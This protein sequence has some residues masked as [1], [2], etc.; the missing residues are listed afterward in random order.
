[1]SQERLAPRTMEKI[2][3]TRIISFRFNDRVIKA[4]PGD[5]VA[6][7]L[8]ASGQRI[9]VRSFKYHR[10]R[11]LLC[12][13]G[14]CPNCMMNV[15]GNPNTRTCKMQVREGIIVR[16]QNAWPSLNHD[17]ASI[18]DKFDFLTPV[19]FYY[20]SFIHPKWMWSAARRIVKR[21]TGIGVIN[22][23]VKGSDGY[24]HANK[25]VDIAI[26]GGGPAGL[27]AAIEASRYGI[28]VLLV[29]EQFDLGGHLKF[30]QTICQNCG[31]FSGLKGFE[32]AQRLSSKV[33]ASPNIEVLT[34]ATCIAIYEG[35]LLTIAQ[36][37]KLLN[38]RASK[39]IICTGCHEH[40]LIFANNDLP[41]IF[42]GSALQRLVN[43]YAL[44]PDGQV[45][46]VT[47]N[48]YGYEVAADLLKAGI[49]VVALSD[50]RAT[51]EQ[52]SV[53][54]R[55]LQ[56]KGVEILP[57]HTIIRA[58]GRKAVDHAIVAKTDRQGNI[59]PQTNRRISCAAI[60]LSVGF[61]AENA[62]LYQAGC[63]F[64]FDEK[65]GE[66]EPREMDTG[67]YAAGEVT[68]LHSL[69]ISIPQGTMNGA[70]AALD[71]FKTDEIVGDL[72]HVQHSEEINRLDQKVARYSGDLDGLIS[73]YKARTETSLLIAIPDS[74]GKKLACVCE[75]V[76]EKDL[77]DAIEEGFDE[78][79][80]LKR[81]STFSMG[82]CQGK[83]CNLSCTAVYAKA[84][85][86][87]L[88]KIA[89]TTSR[90][91]Y[92]PVPLGM[93]AGQPKIVY[94]ITPMHH[95]H[96]ALKARSMDHGDW[97]RPYDYGS[98]ELE[99]KA[100]REGVGLIDVSTL[101]RFE[102]RGR[103]AAKFLDLTFGNIYS[104][105]KLGK[106]R[107]APIFTET[108]IV[109]DD[110]IIARLGNEEFLV[111]CGTGGTE[112]FEEYVKYWAE[113]YENAFRE[114]KGCLHITNLTAG[115][116]AVNIAGPKAREVLSRLTDMDLSAENLPYMSCNRATVAGVQSILLR[117][118]FVG[119]AG[120]EVHFP[121]EYGEYLWDTIMKAGE[122]FG[123]R[124]VGVE[125]MKILRL[126]KKILWPDIDTDR[127]SDGLETGLG[128]SIKFEKEDFVGKH[129]LEKTQQRGFKQ[130]LVGF[131]VDGDS[132]VSEG[133]LIMDR[134]NIVGR[135]TSCRYSIV[136]KKRVG[137][138]WVP[139][140]LA[141]DGGSIEV[142]HR[143]KTSEGKIVQRAFY[144]PEGKRVKE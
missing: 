20:K 84:T 121:A 40:P 12:L 90:P 119:E 27:S 75:D 67:V 124:P 64:D 96:Q 42:L 107:Y 92:E 18:I 30:S 11:G 16:H 125:A 58:G 14:K 56:E 78:I 115:L 108:G 117:I 120:W 83:M 86:Q 54:V 103:D 104:N 38:V 76:T 59:I 143:G 89:R 144:D 25:H 24:D 45:V 37:K 1:M 17:F 46:V 95:K 33:H 9:F 62:L 137:L 97:K 49:A 26:I 8:Y 32:V 28:G 19:G 141:K 48:E 105:M 6:S 88:G 69:E 60:S 79:E 131:I 142:R 98:V 94:K 110:G 50:T 65:T 34:R 122:E 5:T 57:S 13:S 15:D 29:D 136:N 127:S 132:E 93:A 123:I 109:V 35:K 102:I 74:N 44:K 10:P 77:K 31:E 126:E 52:D 39:I 61:E 87:T 4:H 130:K 135:V 106:A 22:P 23:N 133:D 113:W 36:G 73:K 41:G 2:D 80:L 66:Y 114:S 128:W 101:G 134:G 91:P 21:V 81:Y 63:T 112:F 55:Y 129:Y 53:E 68:G 118:G 111:T 82:P 139:A 100:I 47:N 70:M 7:A 99:Y 140:E 138:A 51:A 116:A 71:F 3:R 85:C 43:N 72:G